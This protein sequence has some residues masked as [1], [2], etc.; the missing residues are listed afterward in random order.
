M[1][2]FYNI[3]HN[4]T[5]SLSF[6]KPRD[7]SRQDDFCSHASL[8]HRYTLRIHQHTEIKRVNKKKYYK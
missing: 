5:K 3:L 7:V 1:F 8:E 2:Y 6:M 4:K